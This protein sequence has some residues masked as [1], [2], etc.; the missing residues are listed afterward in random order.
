M[1]PK[2]R[3]KT[4]PAAQ[5]SS[6]IEPKRKPTNREITIKTGA[7]LIVV[8]LVLSLLAGALSFSPS[9]PATAGESQSV[10]IYA[11]DSEPVDTD[12]DGIE[13]NVD[14]DVDGDGIIN[15]E[16]SDIDGDGIENFEDAD[17]IGVLGIDSKGPVK[18]IRPAG[19]EAPITEASSWIWISALT[20][21]LALI[22]ALV[23][24]RIHRKRANKRQN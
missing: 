11:A 5:P 7:I 3:K 2:A 10:Q 21:L 14:P 24:A 9:A 4:K 15:G 8:A 22:G 16:D 23:L 17:P 13:N 12:G 19:S 20:A 18:P 1:S 6:F